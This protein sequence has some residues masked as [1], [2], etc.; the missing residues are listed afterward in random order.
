ME[1]AETTDQNDAVLLPFLLSGDEKEAERALNRL[2]MAQ[3]EPAVKKVLQRKFRATLRPDDFNYENQEALEVF[4]EVRLLLVAELG[5]LRANNG[6]GKC[7]QNL[8]A[9]AA[10]VAVNAFRQY[11]RTKYP[12]RE[13][14]KNKLRYLLTHHPKFSLWKNEIDDWVCGFRDWKCL[15]SPAGAESAP[16]ASKIINGLEKAVAEKNL[17]ESGRVI[18][19]AETIFSFAGVPLPF[20]ELLRAVAEIQGINERKEIS[21]DSEFAKNSLSENFGAT[22]E[23]TLDAIER[24]ERLQNIWSEIRALPLRHRLALLLN[25]KDRQGDGLIKLFPILRVA[26]IREIAASLEFEPAAFA[27]IWIEQ[28]WDDLKIAGYMKQTRQQVINL[29]HSARAR[30]ARQISRND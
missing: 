20:Y 30:I 16:D 25:L 3:I 13:Q 24:R 9:Y 14:L 27:A 11:L 4:S 21:H 1:K 26:S 6:R 12:M 5:K 22:A 28:P 7:I 23:M 10:S 19:L 2:L 8:S 29:R 18:E 15:K 17:R